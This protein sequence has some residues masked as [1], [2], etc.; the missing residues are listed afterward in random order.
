MVEAIGAFYDGRDVVSWTRD[1]GGRRVWRRARAEHSCYLR[2]A[3]V[4]ANEE[5]K[6]WL[7]SSQLVTGVADDGTWTHVSFKDSDVLYRACAPRVRVP[8]GEPRPGLFPGLKIQSFEGDLR[9]VQ[10]WLLEKSVRIVP[11]RRCYLDIEADSR[12]PISKKEQARILSW[13]IGDE[14]GEMVTGMLAEDSNDAERELLLDL[15]NELEA[16]DQIVGWYLDG[17]DKPVIAA[18][19]EARRVTVDP[20]SWVWTD[21]LPIFDRYNMNASKSGD[22]KQSLKLDD[23]ARAVAG[24][25]KLEGVDG[26]QSYALWLTDRPRLGRYNV[27][28]VWCMIKVNEATGYLDV[29]D[30]I[31]QEC[32]VLPDT[33]GA[34]PLRFVDAFIL[35]LARERGM[36]LPS[37]F[38]KGEAPTN[39]GQFEGAY[40]LDPARTGLID[41]VH[42]CDFAGMY[43]SIIRTWNMSAETWAPDVQLTAG[44]TPTYLRHLPADT[45][46]KPIPDGHCAAPND[47]VFRTEPE[48]ILSIACGQLMARRKHWTELQA[49]FPPGTPEATDAARRAGGFKIAINSFYGVQGCP[50]FR[51]HERDVAE[52]VSTTG[53]WLIRL[54][55]A[56]AEKRGWKAEYGD[57]D[58]AFVSGCSE[59]QFREFVRWCNDV[60]FPRECERMKTPRM[61][62]KLEYEKAFE[63]LVMVGKKTYAG[64]YAHYKG[65]RASDASEP[66]IKGLEYKRGDAVRMA[67][68][69]QAEVLDLLLG[70]G[71]K[72]DGVA[73]PRR[74]RCE[75]DPAVFVALVERWKERIMR[76]PLTVD[77]VIVSVVMNK[78]LD[79]YASRKKKDG[80]WAAQPPHVEI[81]KRLRSAGV[82]VG[83]GT[84]I[85]YYVRDGA[86]SPLGVAHE[87]EWKDDVDRYYLWDEKVFEPSHRVLAAAFPGIRWKDHLERQRVKSALKA[88][89]AFA[90]SLS[91]AAKV[92]AR[93]PKKKD[94]AGQGRL[95]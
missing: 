53:S 17:Y 69:M 41:D 78:E 20:R 10:R 5:V 33:N 49:S 77:D 4:A 85:R 46:R 11:G 50:F 25:G 51:V 32:G 1:P 56:E 24:V 68:A 54:V 12:V 79:D 31:A 59:E 3:D 90:A 40:V 87:S 65:K 29:H 45:T 94:A 43:P 89:Q 47:T 36:R 91:R 6:R 83:E 76:G 44:A 48:G 57:T 42:V 61:L 15:F 72:I 93:A 2:S 21:F 62:L 75:D 58:S 30:A 35:R 82:P 34:N 84:R 67:R 7:R 74:E 22:E 37:M 73:S 63:R 55:L 9:P 71:V 81:G 16:Y 64:R 23:V 13:T 38:G 80:N 18:R 26:S 28:D 52:A 92:D 88:I 60:L 70:G 14:Q 19:T 95:F 86:T 27:Q 66:E 39:L 8:D